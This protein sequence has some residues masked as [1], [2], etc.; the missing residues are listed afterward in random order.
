MTDRVVIA[1]D[2]W[3][4]VPAP[5]VAEAMAR[6]W[7]ARNPSVLV[8]FCPQSNGDA[9]LIDVIAAARPDAETGVVEVPDPHGLSILTSYV[10]VEDEG[11]PTAYLTMSHG[12][13]PRTPGSSY[14]TGQAIRKLVAAGAKRVVIG[15]A[16]S[17]TLDGG[18]GLLA[19][20]ADAP[21]PDREH[22]D[23]SIATAAR[24][25]LG[26]HGVQL[27]GAYDTAI[28]LLGL[29]GAAATAQAGLGLD[30]YAAQETEARMSRWAQEL[31]QVLPGRTD[32]LTGQAHRH[33]R[34]PGAGAGGGAGFAVAALGGDLV[35]A[36]EVAAGATGLADALRGSG[37]VVTGTMVFDWQQLTDSVVVQ[38]GSLAQSLALPALILAG[39]VDVGRRELMSLGFSGGYGVVQSPR[40]P[41]PAGPAE[42]LSAAERLAYRV[43]GTWTPARTASGG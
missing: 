35:P 13:V 23:A 11:L 19:G 17:G 37:L 9:G 41:L 15:L 1:T 2:R 12:P 10:Q 34:R 16:D 32:L 26:D 31:A 20:L 4:Q 18:A 24:D 43:A 42:I 27:I 38:V 22:P 39:R 25:L 29:T 8:Q 7:R 14:G 33:D 30:P 3:G 28:P 40:T 5:Q 6:G 21:T 36:S